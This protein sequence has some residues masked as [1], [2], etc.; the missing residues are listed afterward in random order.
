MSWKLIGIDEF[1]INCLV[2]KD[3]VLVGH[4][5]NGNPRH[6]NEIW[7]KP[8]AP[9]KP[10]KPIVKTPRLKIKYSCKKYDTCYSY[11][12]S[13]Y[14]SDID[15][16]INAYFTFVR[17]VDRRLKTLHRKLVAKIKGKDKQKYWPTV[18]KAPS[19]TSEFMQ[20][21]VI[22]RN[23]GNDI[24]PCTKINS[25]KGD[26]LAPEDIKYECY[27][28][29]LVGISYIFGGSDG[30]RIVWHAHQVVVSDV[31]DV[32]LEYCLLDEI[33]PLPP[34]PTIYPPPPPPPPHPQLDYGPRQVQMQ[35]T[36][37]PMV[38]ML[39]IIK[40]DDLLSALGKL[41]PVKLDN[42]ESL[43]CQEPITISLKPMEP[44]VTEQSPG[45]V[46][47]ALALQERKKKMD[48][49]KQRKLVVDSAK[50]GPKNS[51]NVI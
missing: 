37:K 29:Q 24:E 36:G 35:N 8:P 5:D 22:T 17:N 40:K 7:Y 42:G 41:K 18:K 46:L 47:S 44:H 39:S 26:C 4:D 49:A 16:E 31:S 2:I 21:K 12:V 43:P 23:T 13:D 10:C 48:I 11:C 38:S 15:E 45:P 27:T 6:T 30:V 28:D 14:N 19:A 51:I 33:R 20:L 3:Q 50:L 9:S 1:D 32:F 34:V 25:S